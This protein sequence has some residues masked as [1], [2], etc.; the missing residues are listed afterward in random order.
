MG[1]GHDRECGGSRA[2]ALTTCPTSGWIEVPDI[3]P[4]YPHVGLVV[5]AGM[6]R[7]GVH[8]LTA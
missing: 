1:S 7:S 4:I 6:S 5:N 3:R 2:F 8:D